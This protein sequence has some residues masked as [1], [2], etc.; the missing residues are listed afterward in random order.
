MTLEQALEV[1]LKAELMAREFYQ[2]E[3]ERIS[4]PD[5]QKLYQELGEFEEDHVR[6]LEEKL[7]EKGHAPKSTAR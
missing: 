1:G 7:A 4:D 6:R 2:R 5:L 3:A